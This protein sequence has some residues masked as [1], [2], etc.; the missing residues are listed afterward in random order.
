MYF[1]TAAINKGIGSHE[2]DD[3]AYIDGEIIS[4]GFK[5]VITKFDNCL[6]IVCDGVGGESGGYIAAEI[7]LK[8]F[9][10]LRETNLTKNIVVEYIEKANQRILNEQ[11][12]GRM[13]YNMATTIAGLYLEKND[14]LTFNVG[15]SRISRFR[16]PYIAQMTSDHTVVNDL[17]KI[18]MITSREE[19]TKEQRNTITRYLGT[20][21]FA[22][23]DIEHG[24]NNPEVCDL[25][26]LSSDGLHDNV[27]NAE[28]EEI[29]RYSETDHEIVG[30]LCCKAIENGSKDDITVI[31]V[32]FRGTE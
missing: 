15:N 22:V 18:G 12:K 10:E 17:L 24:I 13:S 30:N 4:S 9:S 19:A 14:F 31:I 1:I 23:A 20:P 28:I 21:N 25:F 32:R 29:C 26:L 8:T 2:N 6:L 16:S 27:S 3:R 11:R 5:Q 7:A